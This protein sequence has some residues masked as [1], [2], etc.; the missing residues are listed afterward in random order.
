MVLLLMARILHHLEI[1]KL[2]EPLRILGL[3]TNHCAVSA[4]GPVVRCLHHYPR[5]VK[6]LNC[7]WPDTAKTGACLRGVKAVQTYA[8]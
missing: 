1:L 7:Q 2:Y 3:T 6:G 8:L 4:N 5:R